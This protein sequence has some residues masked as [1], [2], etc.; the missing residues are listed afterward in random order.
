MKHQCPLE[1]AVRSPGYIECQEIAIML[2]QHGVMPCVHNAHFDHGT[3]HPR[4][5]SLVSWAYVNDDFEILQ[6]LLAAGAPVPVDIKR[7]LLLHRDQ[8]TD[9]NSIHW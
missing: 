4:H 8:T 5:G 1:I 6:Y 3:V 2:I 9:I 7:K